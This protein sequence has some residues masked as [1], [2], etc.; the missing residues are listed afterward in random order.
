V[1]APRVLVV[2]DEPDMRWV[3]QELFAGAGFAVECAADA[4]QALAALQAHAF[5][6]VLSDVRM[7]G[8]DGMQL[9]ADSRSRDPDLPVV[10]LSAVADVETAVRAMK[11]GAYDWLAKPFD[12]Q[13]LLGAVR[14]AAEKRQLAR[15]VR[16]LRG[17]LGADLGTS[18]P[19]RELD[20]MLS[21]V[22]GHASIAVLL[23]GESGV[24]KEIAAREIHRR[25]ANAAGPFVAID[26]GAVPESLMESQL[27]GHRRGAF[28]GA[29]NDRPG[30]FT[31]ADGG[32]LFLDEI[33]NLPPPLQPRLLRALQERSVVPVGG[34]EPVPF[35]ARL[36]CA[37]NVDLAAAVQR[38]SFRLDLFHR[39]AELRIE[40]PP[41]RARPQD[42]LHFA[43]RFLAEGTTEFGGQ[44]RGFTAA[45]EAALLQH[46]WPGNLRELRN[47]V[48]RAVLTAGEELLDA[49][50]L[51]LERPEGAESAP[52]PSGQPLAEQLRRALD[53]LE[54][55]ILRDTLERFGGNKA[56]AARALK[57]DYT[58]L[59][60][61][62]KRH[63]LGTMAEVP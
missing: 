40:L 53:A 54:A 14:R 52:G 63:G 8:G 47:V 22:A 6:V 35:R 15:E 34:D 50:A 23:V 30:L 46:P 32:T 1:S 60:R 11:L 4:A 49:G 61:K 43:R 59:H 41:L 36:V 19:A 12:R 28:T 27:F 13:R 24:G 42:V 16:E 31:Q 58:T 39:I 21:V 5:D 10:L 7:A 51:D 38:G 48:R 44:A 55:R 45:A 9:L 25:S 29:D 18:A 62:L 2:D 33:G 20:R 26:C 3:L 56:A 57:V 17:R 37:T